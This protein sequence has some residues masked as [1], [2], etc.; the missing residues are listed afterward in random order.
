VLLFLPD[1]ELSPKAIAI[2][3]YTEICRRIAYILCL[4]IFESDPSWN[5]VLEVQIMG[6]AEVELLCGKFS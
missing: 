6:L 1:L 3:A 5:H 4:N 2:F